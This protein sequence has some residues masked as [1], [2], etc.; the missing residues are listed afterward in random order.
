MKLSAILILIVLG[1]SLFL[2]VTVHIS[3]PSANHI[4]CL[5][6]LDVCNASASFMSA[7]SDIQGLFECP[8]DPAP[9]EGV[10]QNETEVAS[11]ALSLFSLQIEKP[12]K[13]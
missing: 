6:S 10:K 8:C 11:F 4:K 5:V 7:H 13:I 2:P 1:L 12:P 3:L 9:L